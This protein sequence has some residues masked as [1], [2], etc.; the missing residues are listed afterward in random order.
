ML[1]GAPTSLIERARAAIERGDLLSA[2]DLARPDGATGTSAELA[3]IAV[4]AMAR[5]GETEQ[6][7]RLYEMSGLSTAGDV[8]SQALGAR[9]LKDH[10]LQDGSGY[11]GMKLAAEAY[12][13]VYL[14]SRDPFPAI[15]AA[16]LN[17]LAGDV[18][19]ASQF[20][21]FALDA[22]SVEIGRAHV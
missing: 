18:V 5:M 2:Y 10:A 3:Y 16:T 8:D 20:A 9:L 17:L 1:S 13:D 14:R 7:M 4:L 6:A 22:P 12:A 19:R 21:A 11:T 15:N